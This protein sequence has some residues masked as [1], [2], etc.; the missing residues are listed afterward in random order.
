MA[1]FVITG[2]CGHPRAVDGGIKAQCAED[3]PPMKDGDTSDAPFAGT[4]NTLL[5][6]FSQWAFCATCATIVS[7]AAAERVLTPTYALYCLIMA[8]FIC[9]LGMAWT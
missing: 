7:G 5:G 1:Y 9:P 3:T 6:W 8:S 2:A 4:Y